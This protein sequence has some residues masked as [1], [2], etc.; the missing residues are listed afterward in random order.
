MGV[1]VIFDWHISIGT[2]AEVLSILLGGMF[3]LWNMKSRVDLMSLEI[4]SLRTEV[5][6]LSDILTTVAVQDQRILNIEGDIKEMRHGVGF[7]VKPSV[8]TGD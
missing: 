1:D 2:V 6:K 7:I 5:G 3:F 8:F 4:A